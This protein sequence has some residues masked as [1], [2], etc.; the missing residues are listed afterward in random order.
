M[1]QYV[2][3]KAGLGEREEVRAETHGGFAAEQGFQEV[4]QRAFQVAYAH[5]LVYIQTLNLVESRKVGGVNRIATEGA[6]GADDAH[7]RCLLL[8]GA[9]LHGAGLRAQQLTAV[10]VEG[11]FLVAGRVVIR[12]VQGIKA[13][14]LVFNLR[15]VGQCKA[16]AAQNAYG[17]I[18]HNG[19]G[20]QT[21]GRQGGTRH[22]KVYPGYGCGIQL[23]LQG[24]LAILHGGSDDGSGLIEHGAHGRLVLLRHI[25]HALLHLCQASLLA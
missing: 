9:G 10:K 8:H 1:Q 25:A 13:V 11:V 12:R 5:V 19:D 4:L 14:P 7:G 24:G 17:L 16:H 6:A 22:G 18:T 20:V 2:N 23:C 21:T 15:A 3:L